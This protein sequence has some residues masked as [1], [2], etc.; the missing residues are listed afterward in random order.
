MKHKLYAPALSGVLSSVLGVC[1]LSACSQTKT[2]TN[3]QVPNID[4]AQMAPAIDPHAKGM[5]AAA[6]PHAVEAGVE[7]LRAGG[8]AMDAAIAVQSVLSLV[9]PQS[10]GIGGGAFMVFYDAKSGRVTAYNGRETAPSAID[11]TLFDGD[12]GQPIR[13]FTGVMS[14]RSTGAP[15]AVAMLHMAHT[16]HGM[17]PWADG[18]NFAIDL[19]EKGFAVSPRMAGLVARFGDYALGKHETSK[20]Y[21]YHEDGSPIEAGFIRDN[22]PYAE[23]LRAIAQDYRALYEGPIA[24]AIVAAVHEEPLPGKLSLE[25]IKNYKPT[26][27]EAL[28]SPYRTYLICGAQPPSSGGV[29]VQSILGQLSNFDMKALGPTLEGWHVFA[30]ASEMAYADRDQFVADPDFVDVPTKALLAPDYLKSRAGLISMTKAMKNVTAGDPVGFKPGKDNTPDNPGTSHFS[31]VDKF[32]NVV[33]MTTTVEAPFGSER[34]VAGFM[35][36]NQ[37]T[38]FSFSAKDT[39]GNLIANRPEGGKR[40]RSSMSPHIAFDQDGQFSFATGSPGGSSIIAYTAKTI[41]AMIDWGMSPQQAADLANVISRN[42]S[43][44]LEEN[45]LSAEIIEGLEA[46]GHKVVRSRGEISGI[47]IVKKLPDGSYEGAADPRREG[48]ALSE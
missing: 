3:D 41:V 10:S 24:E 2:Q 48:I 36:N 37:L 26:K 14:G 33:S 4:T 11:Q 8:T 25:D 46:L 27:S 34:M 30:E 47:H 9:E 44:R 35:L 15:G 31:I 13:R 5:V 6:N 19:S 22:Q 40:P 28:C 42:G 45:N 1:L 18:F 38:D 12:D 7:A 17:L 21:Y 20:A 23:T 43:V 29:A 16:D 32:G 39:N